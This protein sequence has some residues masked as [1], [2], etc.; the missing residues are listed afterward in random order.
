[1]FGESTIEE[2]ADSRLK[3]EDSARVADSVNG[4]SS[5]TGES[6]TYETIGNNPSSGVHGDAGSLGGPASSFSPSPEEAAS[7][8]RGWNASLPASSFYVALFRDAPGVVGKLIRWQ[9]RS[10]YSH[11]ALVFDLDAV[12]A[13]DDTF[14]FFKECEDCNS[15]FDHSRSHKYLTIEARE[16]RGVRLTEGVVKTWDTNVDLF[17]VEGCISGS[18]VERDPTEVLKRVWFWAKDELAKDYDYTM[19]ARFVSRRQA[20]RTESEK[21]FCSEL[22]FA[23][24]RKAGIE[25][26]R[27]VEPWAVS[28]GLLAKSPLLNFVKTIGP[29]P[30]PELLAKEKAHQ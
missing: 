29:V 6:P 17:A 21:W 22:V 16:F 11:A 27:D 30:L 24:L 8:G 12:L 28:P 2:L 7:L 14:D 18:R 15:K 10:R 1:V 25:L 5:P 26:L 23:A 3:I 19:V 9:T 20:S 4:A 13:I